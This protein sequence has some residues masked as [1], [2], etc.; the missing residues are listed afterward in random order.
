MPSVCS[1]KVSQL[2]AVCVVPVKIGLDFLGP[3]GQLVLVWPRIRKVY[4][5]KA[6][7]SKNFLQIADINFLSTIS[8]SPIDFETQISLQV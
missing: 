4:I 3:Y 2:I 1:Q 7:F 5:L 8:Y 6:S